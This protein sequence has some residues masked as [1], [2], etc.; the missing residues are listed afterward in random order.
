MIQR[1]F[2][3][4]QDFN[5]W[6][7]FKMVAHKNQLIASANQTTTKTITI[8][9]LSHFMFYNKMFHSVQQIL[10]INYCRTKNP[11]VILNYLSN[12]LFFI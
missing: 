9:I 12:R 7:F 4:F 6:Q 5:V 10:N 8:D 11:H 1:T 3:I 2:S